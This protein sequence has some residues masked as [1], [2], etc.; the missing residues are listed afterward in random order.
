[1]TVMLKTWKQYLIRHKDNSDLNQ[2][3]HIIQIRIETQPVG[4]KNFQYLS[5]YKTLACL[6]KTPLTNLIQST[7]LHD[8]SLSSITQTEPHFFGLIGFG[9]R[10]K[11]VRLQPEETFT[12]TTATKAI[13]TYQSLR[14]CPDPTQVPKL[15]PGDESKQ[16]PNFSVIPPT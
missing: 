7:F 9:S 13:P 10:A 14:D 3:A 6:T 11:A 2:N 4:A 15:T 16:L 5:Q 8:E 12:K 1:M